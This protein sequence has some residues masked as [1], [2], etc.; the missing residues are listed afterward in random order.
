MAAAKYSGPIVPGQDTATFRS[1]GQ[2]APL[3]QPFQGPVQPGNDVS[4]F[5]A[6]GQSIPAQA[7]RT[8]QGDGLGASTGGQQRYTESQ[9]LAAGLDFN[10]LRAQGLAS[11]PSIDPMLGEINNAFN[12]RSGRLNSIASTLQSQLP[13]YYQDAD[14]TY[15][16]SVGTL[17]AGKA[18]ST[19]EIDQSLAEADSRKQD[20][21]S[22]ARRAYQDSLIAGSQRFGGGTAGQAYGEIASRSMQENMGNARQSYEQAMQ[23]VQD[24]KAGLEEKYSAGLLQIQNIRDQAKNQARRALDDKL[25]E[26]E[27]MRDEAADAKSAR[28]LSALQDYRSQVFDVNN[29]INQ[30]QMQLQMQLASAGQQADQYAKQFADF[31]TD[32]MSAAG[33]VMNDAGFNIDASAPNQGGD[34]LSM[35]GQVSPKR[36]ELYAGNPLT[37]ARSYFG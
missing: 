8:M 36:D 24:Y 31:G 22:A 19:R 37:A 7:N 20:A 3:T 28:R 17:D 15:N 6:M 1:Q 18:A 9:A 21:L 27:R 10:K 25:I 5:R 2:Y 11:I 12:E 13:G 26:I 16:A 4:V 30:M 33:N 34:A 14:N 29:Q 35:V 32:A 23:K